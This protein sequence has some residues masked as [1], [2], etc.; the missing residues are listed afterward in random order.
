L[1]FVLLTGT[2]NISAVCSAR[3]EIAVSVDSQK[4]STV[5]AAQSNHGP[6]GLDIEATQQR[7]ARATLFG[8]SAVFDIATQS[9][10][11]S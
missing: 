5:R 2:E 11:T 4:W 10:I 7:I 3:G 6:G 8:G 1:T 9:H